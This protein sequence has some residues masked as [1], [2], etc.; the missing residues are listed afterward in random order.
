M[1]LV[2]NLSDKSPLPNEHRDADTMTKRPGIGVHLSLVGALSFCIGASWFE[3]NRATGGNTLSW[4]YVFEWPLLGMFA[5]YAWWKIRH[6]DDATLDS[7][8]VEVSS[9]IAEV[10]AAWGDQLRAIRA[11]DRAPGPSSSTER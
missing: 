4:A 10:Q 1:T 8:G 9:P 11:K 3:I 6:P 2:S 7:T 5:V